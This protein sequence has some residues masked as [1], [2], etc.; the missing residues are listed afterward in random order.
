[1][2]KRMSEGDHYKK[3]ACES[4]VKCDEIRGNGE[5]RCILCG[6]CNVGD[7]SILA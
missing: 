7:V 6:I 2:V 5:E 3:H 4:H 1:M